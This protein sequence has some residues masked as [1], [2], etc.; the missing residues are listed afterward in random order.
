M[1]LAVEAVVYS[2]GEAAGEN[3]CLKL[4]ELLRTVAGVKP[5]PYF[6]GAFEGKECHR[7]GR[8]LQRVCDLLDGQAQ[9]AH[10]TAYRNACSRWQLILPTI[11][12][13]NFI[14]D[15]DIK[16]F[17]LQAAGF[18][19]GLLDAFIWVRVTPKL[20]VLCCHA[21]D[22][23]RRFRSLRRFGEQ[24]LEVLHGR[25][26][27][28]VALF[29]AS[30]F[31]GSCRDF[32]KLSAIG[33]ARTDDVFNNGPRRRPAA[34]GARLA[35]RSDDRRTRASKDSAGETEASR[36]CVERA[37]ADMAKLDAGQA[38]QAATRVRAHRRR[39]EGGASQAPIQC[40]APAG[41]EDDGLL[42]DSDSEVLMGLLGWSLESEVAW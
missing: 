23:L 22:F 34:P 32:V 21:P 1:L 25:F 42:C 28:D 35:T 26:N 2:Q 19:D 20:H 36:A 4:G 5:A 40:I 16:A 12:R 18:V 14:D 3:F 29:P 7:I 30:T 41:E 6:G 39:K 24:R 38:V 17:K 37:T 27:R 9:A 11:N 10:C 13:A 33:G 15:E 8:Q 31:L